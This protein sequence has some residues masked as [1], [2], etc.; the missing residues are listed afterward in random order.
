[1]LMYRDR[2]TRKLRIESVSRTG[3]EVWEEKITPSVQDRV[4]MKGSSLMRGM[5]M[6]CMGGLMRRVVIDIGHHALGVFLVC[7][8]C[9]WSV[10]NVATPVWL[11]KKRRTK[12]F[13]LVGR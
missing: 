11:D 9:G 6:V 8:S 2:Q 10:G 7:D 12:W 13:W 4:A 5:C 3:K 1:M